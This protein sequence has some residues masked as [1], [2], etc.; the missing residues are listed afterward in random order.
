[1]T[2]GYV[3][4]G[5][6][7]PAGYRGRYFFGDFASGRLWSVRFALDPDTGAALAEDEVEHT[8]ELGGPIAGLASFARDL[9]G[10]LYVVAYAGDVF[11]VTAVP[12]DPHPP[13]ADADPRPPLY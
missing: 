13:V 10:E 5:T 7:L 4:R 1:V 11:R 6:A 9:A 3:Y 12:A 8:R 2:G